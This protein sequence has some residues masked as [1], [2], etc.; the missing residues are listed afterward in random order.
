MSETF[1]EVVPDAPWGDYGTVLFHGNV[2][3]APHFRGA[4]ADEVELCRVGPFLPPVTAPSGAL[5]LTEEVAAYFETKGFATN[6]LRPCSI[7]KVVNV[8][9]S[10]WDLSAS[11]PA[12]YPAG[13][14]PGNYIDRRKHSEKTAAS[15]PPL[16]W[17]DAPAMYGF[18]MSKLVEGLRETPPVTDIFRTGF[19]HFVSSRL[20][21]WLAGHAGDFLSFKAVGNDGSD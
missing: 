10:K 19:T 18:P 14:E 6:G 9:M 12:K 20:K 2:S 16:F 7:G 17:V 4:V 13:G 15:L 21:D 3:R 1:F 11:E 8:D 5:V